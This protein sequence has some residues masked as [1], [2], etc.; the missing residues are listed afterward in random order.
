[1]RRNCLSMVVRG[2][3][4]AVGIGVVALGLG[5]GGEAGGSDA[6]DVVA[7]TIPGPDK[8]CLPGIP[9]VVNADCPNGHHCNT[10]AEPPACQKLYCGGFQSAC[11]EDELCLSELCSGERCTAQCSGRECGPDPVYA[12]ASCGTCPGGATCESGHCVC[13]P[14]CDG[15][16]CGD[17]G[18]GGSC[19]KCGDGQSCSAGHC[20]ACSGSCNGE[21]VSIPGGMFQMGTTDWS[22][23]QPV[24]SVMVPAFS[25]GKTEVTVAQYQSCVTAGRC[26]APYSGGSCTL[27]ADDAPVM[28]VDWDQ[29]KA[30]CAFAGGRLCSE[31]EWEFAAR[32]GSAGNLYPWGDT[33]PTSDNAV[34][35]ENHPSLSGP[36]AGCS[37]S[38]GNDTWGVCDL[39]G[40]VS[41]WVEDDYHSDYTGAPTD[42][43]ARVDG[44]RTLRVYRG[45]AF[46]DFNAFFL[47][48]SYRVDLDPSRDGVVGLGA[49]CCKSLPQLP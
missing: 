19:G 21:M 9:C 47:R 43:S 30:Y 35:S 3:A 37:K 24:H 15:K 38:A 10:V 32:N 44:Y 49:R 13:T 31:A 20:K 12:G 40:N 34:W 36:A 29:A 27:G 42:G 16:T 8:E 23:A 39:A 46:G 26:E 7:D 33:D 17:D 18:C 41:E 22:N 25:M 4:A 14:T 28:C 6:G 48:G 11:S 5:C 45:G 1:M 2:I